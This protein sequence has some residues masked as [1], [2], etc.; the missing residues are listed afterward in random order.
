MMERIKSGRA[1]KSTANEVR[2][3]V[4]LYA[5]V[6]MC[7]THMFCPCTG[8]VFLCFL[9][10]FFLSFLPPSSFHAALSSLCLSFS[11]SLPPPPPP[12]F[13]PPSL[14]SVHCARLPRNVTCCRS[15]SQPTDAVTLQ[16]LICSVRSDV[17]IAVDANQATFLIGL[18]NLNAALHLTLSTTP[19]SSKYDV[20]L[21][22]PIV[23]HSGLDD[24]V[25]DRTS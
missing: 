15:Y 14:P 16:R 1:L 6:C 21:V 9:A 11:P 23:P 19:S 22:R 25:S 13:L 24:V 3:Y 2:L 12:P 7:P 8:S 17:F 10:C 20:R 5:H 18:L 4:C